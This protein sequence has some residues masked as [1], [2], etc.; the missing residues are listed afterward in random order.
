M[1]PQR[2]PTSLNLTGTPGKKTKA[3]LWPQGRHQWV[4]SQRCM[5]SPSASPRAAVGARTRGRLLGRRGWGHRGRSGSCP[6]SRRRAAASAWRPC[7]VTMRR[8]CTSRPPRRCPRSQSFPTTC[9]TTRTTRCPWLRFWRL[10]R[11]AQ[12]I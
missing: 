3:I 12:R 9:S 2:G 7:P 6:P 8:A 11:R 5:R 4:R 1:S 10:T